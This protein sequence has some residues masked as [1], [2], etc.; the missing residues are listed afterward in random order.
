MTSVLAATAVVVAA[1]D[2]GKGSPIGLF[3]VLLLVIAVYLLYRSMSGHLRRLPERFPGYDDASP[4]SPAE[5]REPAAGEPE[6]AKPLA[7]EPAAGEPLAG[8][9]LAGEPEVRRE[10]ASDG[11]PTGSAQ[12]G[13]E[14]P[15]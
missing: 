3:V 12:F 8:E 2:T 5:A 7:G 1:S 11:E 15:A 14:R 13:P 10:A 9:P 6:A 4:V